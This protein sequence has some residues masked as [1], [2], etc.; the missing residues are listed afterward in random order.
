MSNKLNELLVK[1]LGNDNLNDNNKSEIQNLQ[2][3]LVKNKKNINIQN[4]LINGFKTYNRKLDDTNLNDMRLKE[5]TIITKYNLPE[6]VRTPIENFSFGLDESDDEIAV[7]L[8]FNH[9]PGEPKEEGAE[10]LKPEGAD[11]Q[12]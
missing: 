10:E 9:I 12:K 6:R 7:N 4:L 5:D 2:E 11:E 1:L 3:F 8:F